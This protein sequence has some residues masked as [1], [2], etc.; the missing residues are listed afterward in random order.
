MDKKKK[1]ILI[2][3]IIILTLAIMAGVVW[4]IG[5]KSKEREKTFSAETSKTN[6][7]Y[8]ELTEKQAYSFCT[9]LDEK[10]TSYYAKRDNMAYIDSIYQGNQ[11]KI[12]IKEGNTYLLAEDQK[13][14][15]TYQNNEVDLKKIEL[16]LESIKEAEYI[17][18]KE[19]I[20]GKQYDYEEYE[21]ITEFLIKNIENIEEQAT[22][23]RFYFEGDKLVYIKTTVGDYEEILKVKISYDVDNKLFEIPSEYKQV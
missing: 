4:W 17:K 3:V 23:T 2:V 15:Y 6:Q 20:N 13:A 19:K 12:V 11:S 7:L 22:K 9:E 14:Y 8:T 16:Q 1:I 18:G 21:G 10:N 5:F